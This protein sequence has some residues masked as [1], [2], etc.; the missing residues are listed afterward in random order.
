MT[1]AHWRR[2]PAAVVRAVLALALVAAGLTGSSLLPAPERAGASTGFRSVLYPNATGGAASVGAWTTV[3]SGHG[4]ST[5]ET[6]TTGRWACV[7]E[8]PQQSDRA[9]T[10][11]RSPQSPT[12]CAASTCSIAFNLGNLPA[13]FRQANVVEVAMTAE[14]IDDGTVGAPDDVRGGFELVEADGTTPITGQATTV[15]PLDSGTFATPAYD[16]LATTSHT[17]A[18]GLAAFSKADFDGAQLRVLH[19]ST[20]NGGNDATA[21]L[22]VSSLSVAVSYITNNGTLAQTGY[23]W[24]NDDQPPSATNVD[25]DTAQAAGGTPVS[26]VRVGERVTT[27]I[28]VKNSGERFDGDVGLF[29]DR[30][31]AIFTRVRDDGTAATGPGTCSDTDFDCTTIATGGG[32]GVGTYTSVAIDPSGVPWVAYHD[33]ANDD[34]ELAHY[35]G[36][37]GSCNGSTAWSCATIDA[38]G[39]DNSGD[40]SGRG[41]VGAGATLGFD[42][43]GNPWIAYRQDD[44]A[45][46]ANRVLRVARF[47]GAGGTGCATTSWS[48]TTVDGTADVGSNPSLAFDGSGKPWVTYYDATGTD[49]RYATYWG[50]GGTGCTDSAWNGCGVVETSPGDVGN[51]SSLAFDAN[52]TP[53]AVY[54]DTSNQRL[55]Y[56]TFNWSGTGTTCGAGATNWDC[57]TLDDS[58]DVG[59]DASLAIDSSGRPTAAYYDATNGDLR[60]ATYV[61]SGGTSACGGSFDG[62]WTC[63]TVDASPD[64]VGHDAHLAFDAAGHPWIASGDHTTASARISRMVGSGGNCSNGQWRCANIDAA[65]AV[66]YYSSLAFDADG[67]AWVAYQDAGNH[68][69]RVAHVHRGGELLATAGG[70]GTTDGVALQASHADMSSPADAAGRASAN[71][72]GGGTWNDGRWTSSAVQRSVTIPDGTGVAQCTELAWV[73]STSQALDGTTYRLA[74]ASKDGHRPDRGLWRG[75]AAIASYPTLTTAARAATAAQVSK[76]ASWAANDCDLD[77]AWSCATIANVAATAAWDT[78]VASDPHGDVWVSFRNN[79]SG[80]LWVARQ[81]TAGVGGT[82]CTDATWTCYSIDA[83]SPGAASARAT[84]LVFD[85]SGTP[86][87]TYNDQTANG[88]KVAHF[89]GSGGSGCTG[90]QSAAWDCTLVTTTQPDGAV[91]QAGRDAAGGIWIAYRDAAGALSVAH[92]TGTG[93]TGCATAQW[94]CAR[95]WTDGGA[96]DV[97]R[98]ALAID[99]DGAPWIAV[100]LTTS[101]RV[102]SARFVGIGGSGCSTSAW[103]CSTILSGTT[104]NLGGGLAVTMA[105]QGVPWLTF[106]SDNPALLMAVHYVGSGGTGCGAGVTSWTCDNV[107]S[108]RSGSQAAI[109]AG[110]DGNPWIARESLSNTELQ[111][112]RYSPRTQTWSSDRVDSAS[113]CCTSFGSAASMA[114]DRSGS[115]W[116]AYSTGS[117]GSIRVAHA[118]APPAGAA[119][120]ATNAVAGRNAATGHLR[121]PLDSGTSPRTE[122]GGCSAAIDARGYCAIAADDGAYDA[123]AAPSGAQPIYTASFR[124]SQSTGLPQLTFVGQSDVAPSTSPVVAE[125]YNQSTG[126]WTPLATTVDTCAGA[127]AN[128]DCTIVGRPNGPASSFFDVAGPD[129]WVHLRVRQLAG[130][131]PEAL[132]VDQIT[133]SQPPQSPAADGSF[134]QVAP[135][136]GALPTNGWTA[137]SA[138]RFTANV[139]D[140]DSGDSDALC[141]EVQPVGAAFTGTPSGC[142]AAVPYAGTA[143]LATVDITGLTGAAYHW[144]AQVRDAAGMTSPWRS[145]GS[146]S[147]GSP[148]STPAAMDFGVDT[149]APSSGTIYRGGTCGVDSAYTDGTLDQLSACWTGFADS[150][151]GIAGYVYSIGTAV[152]GSDVRNWTSVGAATSIT[153]TGLDL[154]TG[155]RYFVNVRAVDAVGNT[156][157]TLSTLGQQVGQILQFSLSDATVSFATLDDSN[158]HA[159][160]STLTVRV[161]TNAH[162]GYAVTSWLDG[163]VSN[164]TAAMA[165]IAAPPSSPAT[166]SGF[167]VGYTV[168]GPTA[169]AT[170]GNGTRWARFGSSNNPGPVMRN[171]GPVSAA[172]LDESAALTVRIAAPPGQPGGR[173][174]ATIGFACL[175]AF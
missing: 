9:G 69:L 20:A 30:G 96:N 92:S 126:S 57:G 1:A 87:I 15:Q 17:F 54:R 47:V 38:T 168:V 22:V 53:W 28:Q 103:T 166:W 93:G 23:I 110:P 152:G 108:V 80:T 66:G 115:P 141:V 3:G 71:C 165:G 6:S 26:N 42:P 49:L 63:A 24:E 73:I 144:Q 120:P 67:A 52:S 39:V 77:P 36:S 56:A 2:R 157:S 46:V 132:K 11:I 113:A 130:A 156:S 102:A 68:G 76:D 133:A 55:R 51:Q 107:G 50:G 118:Q 85:G 89:V 150:G 124:Y 78:S 131:S 147:D 175:A 125:A 155:Q 72:A 149:T 44:D 105:G 82:P 61:G 7:R 33:A 164:G 142:G 88:L 137:S 32:S 174:G 104:G 91:S 84:S 74:I 129:A 25:G 136:A 35:V 34:L 90:A 170:F 13:D 12:S 43:A 163:A 5:S 121:Y 161:Q 97:G 81:G 148:P 172:P 134:G 111:V 109:A 100:Q 59:R 138:V 86:W 8:D 135:S 62:K 14:G 79:T 37:G 65:S 27:R 31:D 119:P 106:A 128:V 4:C 60:L 140:Y 167:G 162:A 64:D 145:Y 116:V 101:H 151:S 114:F 10:A 29:Y 16:A 98:V 122:T 18:S 143:T 123:V 70:A 95:I 94:S 117:G 158:D 19:S 127:A 154:S 112:A 146:N 48:C 169:S 45:T 153:A 160:Q 99:A 75:P 58:A 21:Q 173:Y 41:W 83:S 139:A 171:D 40:G 159:S